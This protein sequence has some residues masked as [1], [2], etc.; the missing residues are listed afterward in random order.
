MY[1]LSDIANSHEVQFARKK[2]SRDKKKRQGRLDKFVN[3]E[4]NPKT[5]KRNV[6]LR[7]PVIKRAIGGAIVGSAI[8]AGSVGLT[9]G[10]LVK[11][12]K[13]P[14]SEAKQLIVPALKGMGKAAMNPK[15]IALGAG[16]GAT[17]GVGKYLSRKSEINKYNKGKHTVNKYEIKK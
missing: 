5:G 1:Y 11:Q 16:I 7:E 17:L 4:V 15:T 10:L 6:T 3:G 2:G 13:L 12:A 8:G 9:A 14:A